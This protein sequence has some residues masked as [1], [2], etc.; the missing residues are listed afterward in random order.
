VTSRTIFAGPWQEIASLSRLEKANAGAYRDYYGYAES[1]INMGI[2]TINLAAKDSLHR[3]QT[4]VAS[5]LL[6]EQRVL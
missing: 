1:L 3:F 2:L 6:I 5:S 4:I